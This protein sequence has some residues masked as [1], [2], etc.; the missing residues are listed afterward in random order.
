M[1]VVCCSFQL[2][3][4]F[5]K[6]YLFLL[7][8]HKAYVDFT[9][10]FFLKVVLDYIQT[11]LSAY[12]K[13]NCNAVSTQYPFD[14][15]NISRLLRIKNNNFRLGFYRFGVYNFRCLSLSLVLYKDWKRTKIQVV[16]VL[17]IVFIYL[18]LVFRS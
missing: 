18:L 3:K 5:L 8:L 6:I 11:W 7:L 15:P 4:Y 12:F 10:I 1:F 17:Q 16:W 14:K 13:Q 9:Q 2:I